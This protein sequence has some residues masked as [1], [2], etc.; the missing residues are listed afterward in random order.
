MQEKI[1]TKNRIESFKTA[2]HCST[3]TL[4][5]LAN[6]VVIGTLM[7]LHPKVKKLKSTLMRIK[8]NLIGGQMPKPLGYAFLHRVGCLLCFTWIK[9]PS[10]TLVFQS[11]WGSFLDGQQD[12]L[13]Y[14]RLILLLSLA[15]PPLGQG[16]LLIPLQA[17][18]G[19]LY[20]LLDVYVIEVWPTEV[21]WTNQHCSYSQVRNF[22]FNMLESISKTGSALAPL[23]VDLGGQVGWWWWFQWLFDDDGADA[24]DDVNDD[25]GGGDACS[26]SISNNKAVSSVLS[27]IWTLLKLMG[28]F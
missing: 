23:V 13:T 8:F 24:A 17:L 12:F 11:P 2:L 5:E 26:C 10:W 1:H 22:G 21:T 7:L 20:Y 9:V 4:K 27:Y 15:L 3:W 6:I 19:G 18:F 25:G 16:L 14:F 28:I